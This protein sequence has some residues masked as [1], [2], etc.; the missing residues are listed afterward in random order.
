MEACSSAML[1]GLE[2]GVGSCNAS[3]ESVEPAAFIVLG[4]RP[5]G[6]VAPA[7]KLGVI[8][9]SFFR[10]ALLEECFVK[11]T[12]GTHLIYTTS[13]LGLDIAS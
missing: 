5:S 13:I 12:Q 6:Q 9:S 7:E 2:G 3:L 4:P 11:G 8:A 1:K 10:F